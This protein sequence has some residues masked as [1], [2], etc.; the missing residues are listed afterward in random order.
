M[1]TQP[2]L[3]IFIAVVTLISFACLGGAPTAVPTPVHEATA[4]PTKAAEQKEGKLEITSSSSYIDSFNDYNVSGVIV[5]HA[6]HVYGNITLGLSITDE[7]GASLLKDANGNTVD[8]IE[9]QPYFTALGPGESTPFNYYISADEVKPAK[10]EVT[11]KSFDGSSPGNGEDVSAENVFMTT[12]PGGNIVITGELINHSSKQVDVETLAGVIFDDAGTV[13]AAN[14]SLT[15]SRYLY[16]SGD[17]QSRDRGPFVIKVYGPLPTAKR[18]EVHS[19]AVENTTPPSTDVSVQITNSYIDGYRNYHLLGT[20]T[21]N[22]TSQIS[23][24]VIAGLST[25]DKTVFDATS[26]NIPLYLNAGESAPFD[27]NSFQTV[28]TLSPEG[29]SAA[30]KVVEPDFYWTY[31]TNYNVVTLEAK[32]IKISHDG[33][34]WTVKGK[35]VN[36]SPEKLSS[37]SVVVLFEDGTQQVMATGSTSIYPADGAHAIQSGASNEFSISLNTP[38]DWNLSQQDYQIIVQGVVA[39]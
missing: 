32:N 17:A 18:Y 4:A 29:A 28:N 13:L 38:E 15:Y 26:L 9:L 19:R 20:V 10:Y 12:T 16:P 1:K 22:G 25:P 36:T 37:V 2:K 39:Q 7:S 6:D 11:I 8:Q 5:N 27:L 23:P 31:S 24:S 21:N 35:V 3:S 34:D 33:S 14:S 30:E